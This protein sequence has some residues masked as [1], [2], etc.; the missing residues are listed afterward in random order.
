MS[1]EDDANDSTVNRRSVLRAVGASAV[2]G[3]S[4]AGGAAAE[5]RPVPEELQRVKGQ[6]DDPITARETVAEHADPLLDELAERDVLA[7]ASTAAFP[8]DQLLDPNEYSDATEGATVRGVR[9]DDEWDAEIATSTETADHVVELVVRPNR[10]RS[11]VLVDP[12]DGGDM[13]RITADANDEVSVSNHCH[14]ETQCLS[15]FACES[16]SSC[17]QQERHC[18]DSD[19]DGSEDDCTDWYNDGCCAYQYCG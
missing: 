12:K 16:G 17:Q 1:R 8:S 9:V 5:R 14:Y 4:F 15:Y 6:L 10:D 18:C 13:Y 3:V 7:T 11:Y 19:G 2:A